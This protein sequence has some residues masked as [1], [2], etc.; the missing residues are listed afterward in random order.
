M[1]FF[2]GKWGQYM[3]APFFCIYYTFWALL[4]RGLTPLIVNLLQCDTS[5]HKFFV[6]SHKHKSEDRIFSL[7]LGDEQEMYV[8]R[9]PGQWPCS[10]FPFPFAG[11]RPITVSIHIS[12][13]HFNLFVAFFFFSFSLSFKFTKKIAISR[14]FTIFKTLLL[15]VFIEKIIFF[16]ILLLFLIILVIWVSVY[17][18]KLVF[19]CKSKMF[20]IE[21]IYKRIQLLLKNSWNSSKN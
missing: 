11:Q 13:C 3:T 7:S 1:I 6:S 9:S 12:I 5:N 18:L 20:W 10:T 15:F 21:T 4:F 2:F 8:T 19:V 16:F 14:N 17:S